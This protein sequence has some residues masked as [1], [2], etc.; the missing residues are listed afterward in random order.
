MTRETRNN[1]AEAKAEAKAEVKTDTSV[2][3]EVL[4]R[5]VNKV[6]EKFQELI[7]QQTAT[8]QSLSGEIQSLR[9]DS[10]KK[11]EEIQKLKLFADHARARLDEL[12]QYGRRNTLLK[13][14]C[15]L[16]IFGVHESA[17]EKV[18][19]LVLDLASKMDSNISQSCID[20]AHRVGKK[21]AGKPRPIIVKFTAYAN[22][23]EMF[24]KKKSLK[25]TPVSIVED[26]TKP[27][28]SLLKMVSQTY[29]K[30]NVWTSDGV[31]LLRYDDKVIR[32]VTGSDLDSTYLKYPPGKGENK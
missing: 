31:I 15:N 19:D 26:L 29:P 9:E 22:R 25:G 2:P 7:S 10:N 11:D 18:E 28:A 14:L 27:R 30:N 12:E 24:S 17:G 16:R 3:V 5:I 8:L 20:R 4:D 1:K 21:I 13:E 6:A 32:I 23:R